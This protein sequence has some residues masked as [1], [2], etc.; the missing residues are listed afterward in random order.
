[1]IRTASVFPRKILSIDYQVFTINEQ[2]LLLI[3]FLDIYSKK[4]VLKE[5]DEVAVLLIGHGSS[6]TIN[7]IDD[8]GVCMQTPIMNN[9]LITVNDE[10]FSKV[11]VVASAFKGYHL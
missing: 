3:I 4:Q 5:N 6:Q 9:S 1:M 8:E 11:M 10:Q 7:K 2:T